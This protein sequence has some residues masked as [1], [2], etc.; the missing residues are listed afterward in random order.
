MKYV[1]IQEM[2]RD[3]AAAVLTNG[4]TDEKIIAL[5]SLA[6]YDNDSKWVET[7][8]ADYLNDNNPSLRGIAVQCF[9]HL[10][11]IHRVIH[12]TVI[13]DKIYQLSNDDNQTVRGQAEGAISDFRIFLK[14]KCKRFKH[15]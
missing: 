5:L 4:T 2:S 11:R 13:I 14:L 9:G 8:C 1:E 10:A 6:L 12:D 7:I 15:K 3:E